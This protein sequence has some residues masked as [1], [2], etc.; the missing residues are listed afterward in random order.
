MTRVSVSRDSVSR[1]SVSRVSRPLLAVGL[2]AGLLFP[3][4]VSSRSVSAASKPT[5]VKIVDIAMGPVFYTPK[6]VFVT[7]GQKVRFRFKNNATVVHEALVGDAK[8][9][10]KHAKEMKK[11]GD[12]SGH[13]KIKGWV[14]VPGGKTATLDW[15]FAKPGR[16][17]IG[18]HQPG[19]YKNMVLNVVIKSGSGIA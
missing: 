9:Q 5:E 4:A 7:A 13:A 19:H 11:M 10:E 8:A 12:H 18:C 3:F 15:T 17:L 2:A 1:D 6:T 16:T 14:S